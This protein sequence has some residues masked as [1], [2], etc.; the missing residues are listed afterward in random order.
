MPPPPSA[1]PKGDDGEQGEAGPQGPQGPKGKD[2]AKT[3]SAL[4]DVNLDGLD[5]GAI[6]MWS[7]KEKKWIMSLQDEE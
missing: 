1:G 3:F 7:A 5:D 2:G 6:P 4:T